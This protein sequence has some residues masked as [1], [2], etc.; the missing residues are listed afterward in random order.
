M[1]D[2]EV[3]DLIDATISE[4]FE[5]E[6]KD[7]QP[8]ATLFEE[9][10]FDSLDVVD[11]VVALE[12]AFQFKIREEKSVRSIRTLGDVHAFVLAKKRALETGP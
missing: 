12:K 10:G 2:Q 4:E 7:L 1:T 3:V 6:R 5:I 11:L 8:E 9:L